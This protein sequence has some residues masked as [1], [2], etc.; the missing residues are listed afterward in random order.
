MRIVTWNCARGPLATKRAALDELAPD[1]AIL[2]EASQP[3]ASDD[4]VLWFGDGKYGVAMYAKEPFRLRRMPIVAGVPCVYPVV[5]DGPVTFSLLG[6]WTRPAPTYKKAFLNGLAA[7][8]TTPAPWVVAGDFNGNVD[9]DRPKGRAK[10]QTCFE[11]LTNQGLVSAYHTHSALP[12]G[13]EPHPTH[14]FKWHEAERFHLDYCFVPKEWTIGAVS[15]GSYSDWAKL[16][17]HRPL[18]VDIE[19]P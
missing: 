19:V 6:V 1:V 4:D 18:T 3:T 7:H 8:A 14:Y 16:S 13:K 2:T 11:Q 9:F 5:V 12:F 17:D 15:V 10:W